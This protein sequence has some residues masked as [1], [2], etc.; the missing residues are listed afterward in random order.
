LVRLSALGDCIH[1][2]PVVAALREALPDAHLGWAIAESGFELLSPH[3]L[4]DRF[5]RFPRRARGR[6]RFAALRA[7]RAEL[8]AQRYDIA[9]DLQGLAKSGLVAWW[10]GASVRLGFAGRDSRELNRLFLNLRVAPPAA[11]AHVVDRNLSLLA[12]LGIEPPSRGR[13]PLPALLPSHGL[14]ELRGQI[15]GRTF[16]V[17]HPGTTWATKRWPLAAWAALAGELWRTRGLVSVVSWGSPRERLDAQEIVSGAVLDAALLAPPTDL[18]DLAS[19]LSAAGLVVGADTGPMHL[20]VAL[21]VPTVAVFG[22]SDPRRNG[23]YGTPDAAV[24]TTLPLPCR[25]CL[26]RDC[27]R[28]DLA[29]LRTLTPDSVLAACL[30]RL[31]TVRRHDAIGDAAKAL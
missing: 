18:R 1:A 3:P 25:P 21:E 27:A 16:A 11:A 4:V 24:V 17:L 6:T 28:L 2:L 26:K 7:F 29:C 14:A 12:A 31:E 10:S 20:A 5:H 15:G 9:I 13:F 30:D 8:R 19:L 22:A 23:P